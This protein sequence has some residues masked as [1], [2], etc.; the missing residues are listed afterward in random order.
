MNDLHQLNNRFAIPGVLKIEAGAGG[1]LRVAVTSPLA[2]AHVYL[3][4]AHVTHFAARG[5]KPFLF[6]SAESHFASDTPIRGGVP[7]CFPWF[8]PKAGDTAAP[9][10]GFARLLSW[11]VAEI[12]SLPD[13]TVNVGLE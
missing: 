7:I 9:M 10:H 3:H 12:T 4:G 11:D 13:G 6:L 2:E 8:G 1:L 5:Q